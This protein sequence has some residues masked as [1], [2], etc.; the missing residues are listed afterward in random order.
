L[1][2]EVILEITPSAELFIGSYVKVRVVIDPASQLT[3]NNLDF[4]IPEGPKGGIV[5]LSR[6]ADFNPDE[7]D[8]MLCAGY[9]PGTYILQALKKGTDTVVAEQEFLITDLWQNDQ[10]GPSQWFTG[11]NEVYSVGAKWGTSPTEGFPGPQNIN[12]H[13]AMGTRRIAILLVDTRSERYTINMA[14]LQGYRD[15]WLN[16]TVRGV[17]TGG[18]TRSV[19]HYYREVSYGNFD[20]SAEVFG[21]VQL[22]G[23]WEDYFILQD[24]LWLPKA[25]FY[26][27]CFSAG[28][29]LIDYRQFQTLLI[30]SQSVNPTNPSSR[31]FAWPISGGG[32]FAT[33]EGSRR[34]RIISMPNEWHEIDGREI[35]GTVIHELGHNLDLPDLYKP[36]V[37]NGT[38]VRNL[39]GWDVMYSS[40]QL[41]H[42]SLAHRMMLGWI[43]ADK[44][45]SFN[46]RR[47]MTS[48]VNNTITLH[49]I[50]QRSPPSGTFYG[51]EVRIADGW[52]YYFEYRI[53][54]STQIGDRNLPTDNRVLGTDVRPSSVGIVSVRPLILLLQN[55]EDGD[56][57]VIGNGQNYTEI[58]TTE[59]SNPTFVAAVTNIDGGT[60]N[61]R[62]RYGPNGRPDPQ[63]R[64]WPAG[65]GRQWQS[66]DIEV[67]NARSDT[68]RRW[69]NVPWAGNPNRVIAYVKNGGDIDARQVRVNFYVSNFNISGNSAPDTP[70]GSAIVDIPAGR[71]IEAQC[72]ATW[73]PP[74]QGHYCI[75]VRI[76]LY[77]TPAPGR[78]LEASGGNNFAQSNYTRFYSGSS[79][80][81]SREII[82][83]E[84]KN[85][86]D[87]QS[88]IF[89]SGEQTNPLYRT[90][91]EH[92]SLVLEPGETRN[93]RVMF[94][95]ADDTSGEL[96]LD[97][98]DKDKYKKTPNN[99]GL[100]AFIEDPKEWPPHTAELLGGAQIEVVTG[101]STKF[102]NF[103]V[104]GKKF[105]G[106]VVTH[107]DGKSVPDGKV[108]LIFY[109]SKGEKGEKGEKTYDE[110]KIS[111]GEFSAEISKEWDSVKAYF[112]PPEGYDYGYCMSERKYQNSYQKLGQ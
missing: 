81:G 97:D 16:E 80:P 18:V 37:Q 79:S 101:R 43:P 68:D 13:S 29:N 46:F 7:P 96:A 82:A 55:D 110:L 31:K 99:V 28:D 76:P 69:L 65:P 85:P 2:E 84:V 75:K 72:N 83:V 64:E 3:I 38:Q 23:N 47:M 74:G 35:H 87:R 21:P 48:Q 62:I 91:I 24:N 14:I 52:N 51:I 59:V 20:I 108:L 45:V 8:I 32:M 42:F 6:D 50:E 44:I 111:D 58:D 40:R 71:T 89:I 66:P 103:D 88:R 94:E 70:L 63:I 67:R 106:K 56:G 92:R 10:A 30:V 95:Y 27:A 12:V 73:N 86:Y 107:D 33:A 105:N 15:R 4:K 26:Q 22:S 78:I 11:I 17:V 98:A 19:A 112:I 104:D 53:G 39:E 100:T 77:Q 36:P 49:P 34:Y 5:S 93:I 60:A 57:S 90:F 109:A 9:E 61:V 102:E 54:Q 41:P 25:N 1:S